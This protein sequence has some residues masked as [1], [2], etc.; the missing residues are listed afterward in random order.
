MRP[1]PNCFSGGTLGNVCRKSVKNF[2]S[3]VFGD[4]TH[5]SSEVPAVVLNGQ[6]D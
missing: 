1:V 3:E 6:E 5:I 4:E 2:R